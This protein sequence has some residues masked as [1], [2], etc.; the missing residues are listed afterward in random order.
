MSTLLRV[1]ILEDRQSDASLMVEALRQFGYT[2][3]WRRVETERD[4]LTGLVPPPDVI[5]ADYHQPQFDAPRALK[6]LQESGLD[7]PFLVV[8]GA[9][10]DE[11]AVACMRQGA[12]DFLLKDRLARL[13]AAVQQAL[14]RKRARDDQRRAAEHILQLNSDLEQRVK[15]RTAELEATNAEL[16]REAQERQRAELEVRRLSLTD[17]LTGLYNRRGF[18]LRAEQQLT[19]AQRARLPC[20]VLY[21]DLDGLKQINDRS[22]HQAGDVLLVEMARLLKQTLREVDVV[23]RLGGD[24]FAVFLMPCTSAEN[25]RA[26]LLMAMSAFSQQAEHPHPLCASVGFESAEASANVSLEVLL[27]RADESMYAQKRARQAQMSRP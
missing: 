9:L 18:F 13:G 3:D 23:A 5:L 1:L 8:T 2:L 16:R 26:R 27:K 25:V 4:F 21:I 7:I 19:I 15:Q 12:S 14:G 11:A 22:G 10:G 17:E 6:L 20:S 24:E